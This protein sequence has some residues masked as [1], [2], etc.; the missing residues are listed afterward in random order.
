MIRPIVF[1]SVGLDVSPEQETFIKSV[2]ER[3]TSEGFTAQTMGRNLF[4]SGMPLRKITELM[5]ESCGVVVIALER[6]HF[7]SGVERKG[8]IREKR[9][10]DVRLPTVWNQIEAA[11]SYAYDK[12]LLLIVDKNLNREGLLEDKHGWYVQS[13]DLT[14]ISLSS[15]AFNGILADW[16]QRVMLINNSLNIDLTQ[17]SQPSN[18]DNWS[19]ADIWQKMPARIIYSVIGLLIAC[20]VGGFGLG[21][22]VSKLNADSTNNST[23]SPP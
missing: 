3:L 21:S 2:E 12:P 5:K 14:N 1:L 18:I 13:V 9:V 11:M 20:G 22:Y 7:D 8:S 15:P 6:Y 4:S 17:S 23:P 16:K 10:T 19:M